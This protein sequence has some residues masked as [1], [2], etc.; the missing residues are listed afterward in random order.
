M[1]IPRR[2]IQVARRDP[3]VGDHVM[4]GNEASENDVPDDSNRRSGAEQPTT[5]W[6]SLQD[7]RESVLSAH[8]PE[9]WRGTR[10]DPGRTG[11]LALCAVGAIVLG[12][13]G[14]SVLRDAPVSAPVPTLPVV[15][16]VTQ[17]P[18]T[19]TDTA[20]PPVRIVVSVVGLVASPGLVNLSTGS[21]VADALAAAGGPNVGADVLAL[22]LAAKVSDG[23]QIVVGAPPPEGRPIVSGTVQ[24]S[25]S[26]NGPVARAGEPAAN[27]PAGVVNLNTATVEELDSLAG[28]GPV[29]AAS[30][31]AWRET[32]GPFTDVGQLA[33]VDGIGPVR[34]EKLRDQVAV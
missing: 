17:V 28:V 2:T 32:N 19:A 20:E 21:R 4:P 30:I 29:T 12:V 34:L 6:L 1:P 18:V 5:D 14:F 9:R 10:L 11:V 16:P 31:V 25:G 3:A 26:G 22:N 15:Q 8:L 7:R 23:D 24:D 27:E 13:A 33:E